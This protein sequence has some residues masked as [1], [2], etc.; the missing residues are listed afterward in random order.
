MAKKNTTQQRVKE[1]QHAVQFITSPGGE[2]LAIMS[3]AHFDRLMERLE[4]MADAREAKAILGRVTRGK[5]EVFPAAIVRQTLSSGANRIRI[6]RDYRA[7]T[8]EKLAKAAGISRAYLTQIENGHRT[9][10]AELY[11]KLAGILK[12]DMEMLMPPARH[13]G[14][15]AA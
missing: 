2:E 4:D 7:M 5:E 9:G 12:V 3:R 8:A 15:R 1:L 14:G 13:R 11:A 10:P 6:W